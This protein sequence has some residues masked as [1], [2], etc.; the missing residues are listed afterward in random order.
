M[1]L[2]VTPENAAANKSRYWRPADPPQ[3]L[4]VQL[5]TQNVPTV[6]F[7]MG[8]NRCYFELWRKSANGRETQLATFDGA[9]PGAVFRDVLAPV[10]TALSYRVRAVHKQSGVDGAFG[11]SVRAIRPLQSSIFTLPHTNKAN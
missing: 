9:E 3:D 6:T 1:T 11:E 4:T 10:G 5:D 2:F 7:S 8:D